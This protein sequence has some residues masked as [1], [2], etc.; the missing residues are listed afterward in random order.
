[1]LFLR[2][3]LSIWCKQESLNRDMSEGKFYGLAMLEFAE[4][5][6]FKCNHDY[7]DSGQSLKYVLTK[8]TD[9]SRDPVMCNICSLCGKI[10][11]YDQDNKKIVNLLDLKIKKKN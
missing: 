8:K 7:K 10:I 9:R 2:R 1:M 4:K 5:R 3:S 6:G 11:L